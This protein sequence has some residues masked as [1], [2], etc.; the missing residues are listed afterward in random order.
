MRFLGYLGDVSETGIFV[1]C[2]NPRSVGA[3]LELELRLP[4]NRRVACRAVEIVWARSLGGKDGL[5]PGMGMR[6]T[7]LAEV[8]RT[9]L[10]VFC[11]E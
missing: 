10:N 2:S 9:A 11:S 5:T 8:S 4:G 6:F 3:S 1:Q 7:E